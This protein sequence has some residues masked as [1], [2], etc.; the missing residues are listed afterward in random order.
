M[1]TKSIVTAALIIFAIIASGVVFAS[2][3]NNSA[4]SSNNSTSN[5]ETDSREITPPARNET[6][7]TSE[8]QSTQCLITIS[9]TTYDLEEFRTSHDGGDVFKCGTDMTRAFENQHDDSFLK[10]IE[11]YKVN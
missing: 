11:R 6:G 10:Q 2:L 4:S 7:N 9:G 5:T 8:P 3:Q 1:K